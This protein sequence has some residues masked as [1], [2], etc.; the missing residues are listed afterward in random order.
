MVGAVIVA[1]LFYFILHKM[2][3]NL[4]DEN[5]YIILWALFSI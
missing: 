3:S 4:E 2:D 1:I 5:T